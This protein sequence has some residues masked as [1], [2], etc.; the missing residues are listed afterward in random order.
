MSRPRRQMEVHV[1]LKRSSS[2]TRVVRLSTLDQFQRHFGKPILRF[3]EDHICGYIHFL[4]YDRSLSHSYVKQTYSVLKILCER[5]L[6]RT[7]NIERISHSKKAKRL[8]V[9]VTDLALQYDLDETRRV[10]EEIKYE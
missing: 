10:Q 9:V 4:I 8:P 1:G 7:W 3:G 2:R 5:I 6:C